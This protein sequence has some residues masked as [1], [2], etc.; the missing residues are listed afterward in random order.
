MATF[1]NH[2]NSIFWEILMIHDIS[3]SSTSDVWTEDIKASFRAESGQMAKR[4][5]GRK[6]TVAPRNIEGPLV[7]SPVAPVY[8]KTLIISNSNRSSN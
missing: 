3:I 7:S 4:N 2:Q 6:V 5:E 1:L 8:G